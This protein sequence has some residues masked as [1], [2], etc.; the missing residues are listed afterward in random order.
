MA[1]ILTRHFASIAAAATVETFL[2]E[3]RWLDRKTFNDG[4]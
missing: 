2:S 3:V 1:N 4:V